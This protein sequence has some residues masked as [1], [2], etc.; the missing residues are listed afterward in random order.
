[1]SGR[2]SSEI[3]DR[4]LALVPPMGFNTWNCF[5]MHIDERLARE[6]IEAMVERGLAAAGYR[7]F[8]LDDGWMAPQR[9]PAGRLAADPVRFP[10]GMAGLADDA[11]EAGLSF[12]LY[13]DCGHRTCGGLPSSYGHEATDA[14]CF[15]EWGVDYLKHDWCNVPFEDFP[16]ASRAD[17]ARELYGRM[18]EALIA[19]GRPVV[20]SMCNWGVGSPWEW[21]AGIAH[22]WRTTPDIDDRW[23]GAGEGTWGLA[24]VFRHNAALDRFAGPGGWNDPDMLEV[25]NGGM[26]SVEYRSHF[27]LWCMMA[28]PLMIGCDVR[29]ASESTIGILTNRELIAVDQD[30]V[31][32]QA[33]LVTSEGGLHTLRKRLKDGWAVGVFNE[34]G[35]Q[36]AVTVDWDALVGPAGTGRWR[37]M[38]CWSATER[39]V[40]GKDEVL[41]S[42]HDT[43]V[44]RLRAATQSIAERDLRQ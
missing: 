43:L 32:Q 1:M 38:D 40:A 24:P 37:A 3:V 34:T 31:G 13:S 23:S 42:A 5:R 28:A 33:Q 7:Y 44:W 4:S 22:L 15:A 6:T 35:A 16:G 26:S 19:T 39:D 11:H 17:V 30:P 12:G 18:A 36:L 14:L 8:N 9:D 27:A 2:A 21:A 29:S 20:L 41:V 10:S 25:G